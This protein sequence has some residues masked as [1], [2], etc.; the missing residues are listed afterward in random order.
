MWLRIGTG[1]GLLCSGLLD[2]RPKPFI[3]VILRASN[4]CI[5]FFVTSTDLL[6]TLCVFFY[7]IGCEVGFFWYVRTCTFI[8]ENMI[9]YEKKSLY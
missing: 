7:L 3:Y 2:Y 8:L 5:Y 1:E 9:L 4:L 6:V